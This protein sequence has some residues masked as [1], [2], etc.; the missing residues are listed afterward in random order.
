MKANSFIESIPLL[1]KFVYKDKDIFFVKLPTKKTEK[2]YYDV[3]A[4]GKVLVFPD[5]GKEKLNNPTI[6]GGDYC[7]DS[8][9]KRNLYKWVIGSPYVTPLFSSE[10]S[11]KQVFTDADFDTVFDCGVAWNTLMSKKESTDFG[12]GTIK[13][14]IIGC[15]I[16]GV[17][18]L[19]L[20]Y[21]IAEEMGI[22]QNLFPGG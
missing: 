19:F 6:K 8:K 10:S 3:S 2:H 17:V 1:E 14:L 9:S 22:L 21:T 16:I 4:E 18:N 5:S 12:A 13:M 11:E 7:I 20:V 15:L